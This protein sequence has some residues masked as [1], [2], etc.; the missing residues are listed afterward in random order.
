VK[1]RPASLRRLLP[2]S[3][4]RGAP[5]P[6]TPDLGRASAPRPADERSTQPAGERP[7]AWNLWELERLAATIDGPDTEERSLLLLHLREFAEPA[8]NLPREFDPLV[9]EAFGA[10]LLEFA[11]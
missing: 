6:G 3:R 4:E 11:G 2:G 5:L 1:N 10:D 9:R 7:R 8:G